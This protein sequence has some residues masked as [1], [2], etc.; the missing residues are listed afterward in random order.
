M[1]T[2]IGSVGYR[3]SEPV[4]H[5]ELRHFELQTSVYDSSKTTPLD[6]S[7]ICYFSS[8]KR[9]E[10][11][12]VPNT[13]SC[14]SVTAKVVG[15]TTKDNRLAVRVL[16]MSYIPQS[17]STPVSSPAP[18]QS[19]SLKRSN[20]W[21]GRV[22]SVTPSKKIR[23]SAPEMQSPRTPPTIETDLDQQLSSTITPHLNNVTSTDHPP[24][25]T[26]IDGESDG[27]GRPQRN[28]RPPKIM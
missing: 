6:F 2:I 9:W 26:P 19:T 20:R 17:F 5:F 23:Y 8:G 3:N 21:G 28:R 27:G 22:E 11:V 1:L 14:V 18:T 15:R 12:K 25:S 7:V 24:A 16:D 10:K 4:G 13:G